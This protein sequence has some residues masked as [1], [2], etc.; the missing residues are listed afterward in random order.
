MSPVDAGPCFTNAGAEDEAS[1]P[2]SPQATMAGPQESAS[3]RTSIEGRR[4]NSLVSDDNVL[5]EDI[6]GACL[7]EECTASALVPA[8]GEWPQ[9]PLSGVCCPAQVFSKSVG[10]RVLHS[11]PDAGAEVNSGDLSP[12]NQPQPETSKIASVSGHSL[13]FMHA[14][15]P[16]LLIERW[17]SCVS[18]VHYAYNSETNV[19]RKMAGSMWSTSEAVYYTLQFMSVS[20]LANVYPGSGFRLPFLLGKALSA[21]KKGL[22]G[23][24]VLQRYVHASIPTDIIFA[25]FAVGTSLCWS[26]TADLGLPL[27]ENIARVLDLCSFD[28]SQL[29]MRERAHYV[30]FCKSLNYWDM[31][32]SITPNRRTKELLKSR[33]RHEQMISATYNIQRAASV[34]QLHSSPGDSSSQTLVNSFKSLDQFPPLHSWA[35][36]SS[37]GQNILGL[38]L[39]L[40]RD[41]LENGSQIS[42]TRLRSGLSGDVRNLIVA[43]SLLCELQSIN[44]GSLD[45]LELGK[46]HRF[47]SIR[48]K[49]DQ[50]PVWHLICAAEAT[51]LAA[52]L[53]LHLKFSGLTVSDRYETEENIEVHREGGFA[54]ADACMDEQHSREE[55]IFDLSIELLDVLLKIPTDS[56]S[57]K[58]L[59]L[60]YVSA[61]AGL[62]LPKI[63]RE[64]QDSE[65]IGSVG[66]GFDLKT[67]PT[68][69]QEYANQNN[70]WKPLPK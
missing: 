57:T 25:A 3:P 61:A 58:I 40:C 15:L 38:T 10:P 14:D 68:S 30:H 5:M 39:S 46:T 12:T 31:L 23:F 60:L 29:S 45:F 34:Y 50:T 22:A 63:S 64:F 9:D 42:F 48:T 4:L 47:A 16:T 66:Y 20:F 67:E 7:G 59:P 33:K 11:A 56:G 52:I 70:Q 6:T 62:P 18:R 36:I 19:D 37:H 8:S 21:I 43:R 1:R 13:S 35:G 54:R 53:Q 2:M 28:D 24:Y 26:R 65:V 27:R 55:K 17:F 49:D 41:E 32:V 51:R 69:S 44:F